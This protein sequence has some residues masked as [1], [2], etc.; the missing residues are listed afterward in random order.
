MGLGVCLGFTP[1]VVGVTCRVQ[2]FKALHPET[3]CS[4]QE[5]ISVRHAAVSGSHFH[6]MQL[7]KLQA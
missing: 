3:V 1:S 5:R 2:A 6:N 7:S 4:S